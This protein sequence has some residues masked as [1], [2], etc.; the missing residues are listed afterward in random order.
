M[1]RHKDI[2]HPE[3]HEI[4]PANLVIDGHIEQGKVAAVLRDL[5]PHA[6]RPDV[7]W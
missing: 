2:P 7:L 5:K 6:D 4:T 1:T 3:P